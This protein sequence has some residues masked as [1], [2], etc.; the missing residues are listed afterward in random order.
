MA[1]LAASN[2]HLGTPAKRKA[3]VHVTVATSSAIEGIRV[4]KAGKKAKPGAV[5]DKRGAGASAAKKIK[6]ARRARSA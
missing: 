6:P 1:S 5:P 4:F 2:R 3:A